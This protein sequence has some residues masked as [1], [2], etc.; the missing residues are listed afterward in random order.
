M[1]F[2]NFFKSNTPKLDEH[3]LLFLCFYHYSEF[4]KS[5][6]IDVSEI[7]MNE[8]LNPNQNYSLYINED[9]FINLTKSFIDIL[10]VLE[11]KYRLLSIDVEK[12]MSVYTDSKFNSNELEIDFTKFKKYIDG[13]YLNISNGIYVQEVYEILIFVQKVS[14]YY[15]ENGENK[16]SESVFVFSFISTH[17]FLFFKHINSSLETFKDS[18]ITEVLEL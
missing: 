4:I 6:K 1:G 17:G 18:K 11:K 16:G 13:E 14:S 5:K 9:D 10:N 15:I 7:N 12:T 3:K 8:T 2:F